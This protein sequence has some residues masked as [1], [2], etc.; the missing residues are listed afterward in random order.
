MA[1]VT[2]GAARRG[3]AERKAAQKEKLRDALLNNQR[4][5]TAKFKSW[6]EDGSGTIDREEFQK[7]IPKFGAEMDIPMLCEIS[8]EDLG[9]LFDVLD[10]DGSGELE[11]G[12]LKTLLKDEQPISNIAIVNKL[13]GVVQVLNSTTLQ[14][15]LYIAFVIVF[16]TLT[17][18]M[19]NPKHE[20]YFDKML[21]DTILENHFDASH[22]YFSDIRRTADVWEW[23]NTVLL[24]GLLANAGPSGEVGRPGGLSAPDARNDEVWPDGDYSFHME[25]ATP[26]TVPE[27]VEMMDQLDW[28]EGIYLRQARVGTPRLGARSCDAL[29]LP[30][31]ICSYSRVTYAPTPG[32]QRRP[33]RPSATPSSSAASAIPSWMRSMAGRRPRTKPRLGS[34]GPTTPPRRSIRTCGGSRS[35]W[36]QGRPGR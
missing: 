29:S 25:G 18:T 9:N 28:T 15:I 30:R 1:A 17:E 24:S 19:R 26:Y 32:Q 10:E 34:T 35:V 36:A 8:A 3:H 23:G 4:K 11:L 21:G 12:E 5:L 7:A 33:P 16:Q 14:T 6:D 20:Y 2:S 13:H 31:P 22:N 27:L